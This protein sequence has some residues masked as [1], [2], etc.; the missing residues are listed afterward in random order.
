[1]HSVTTEDGPVAGR[2]WEVEEP[3]DPRLSWSSRPAHAH[4]GKRLGPWLR[5]DTRTMPRRFPRRRRPRAAVD[6]STQHATRAAND[7]RLRTGPGAGIPAH[8][9]IPR[10]ETPSSPSA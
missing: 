10:R 7:P 5:V 9:L 2:P 6:S 8:A 1:F 3:G 4:L